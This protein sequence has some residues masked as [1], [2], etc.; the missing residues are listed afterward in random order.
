MLSIIIHG[1]AWNMPESLEAAHMR[2][3][4][5]ACKAGRDALIDGNGSSN[6]VAEA[7]VI[8]EEDET[9]DAGRGSFLNSAGMVEL[10]AGMMVS[11]T[12][13]FASLGAV[14]KIRNP[15]LLCR[16]ML[17]TSPNK[18]LVG[19]GAH[20][21]AEE[22]GITL[23][24]NSELCTPRERE[25]YEKKFGSVESYFSPSDTVG[26]VACDGAGCL[27][28]GNTTGGTPGKPPGRVGDSPI[29]GCGIYAGVHGGIAATGHGEPIIKSVL[30]KRIY[31]FHV[32]YR[33][34]D[35]AAIRGIQDLGTFGWGGIIAMDCNGNTAARHNTTKMPYATW[36][37]KEDSIKSAIANPSDQLHT[38]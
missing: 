15:I 29:V 8:M 18:F 27:T 20:Q 36:N 26:A 5:E 24:D 34:I 37:E 6:A 3:V 1:G 14:S 25:R 9:F 17:A 4:R 21:F 32:A 38:V 28:A 11:C 2:G 7:L 33:D 16:D 30:A 10:D 31:D 23:I 13:D 19:E 12:S 22:N 35:R